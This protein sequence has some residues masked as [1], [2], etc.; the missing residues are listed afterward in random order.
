[1][2]QLLVLMVSIMNISD[3]LQFLKGVGPKKFDALKKL[4]LTTIEDFLNYYPRTYEDRSALTPFVEL[5]AGMSV[6]TAGT[7][8][9][10]MEKR[11]ARGMKLLLVRL[12]DGTGTL[13]AVWFNQPFLKKQLTVGSRLLLS[14]KIDYTYGGHGQLSMNQVT[15]FERLEADTPVKLGIIPVYPATEALNQKYLRKISRQIFDCQPKIDEVIPSAVVERY[16]LMPRAEAVREMHFPSDFESLKRAHDTLAF[17]ELYVIQCGLLILK[18]RSEQNQQG[19]RHMLSSNL[20][21][22]V[23]GA[24]PFA[25]TE[26]Q[27]KVLRD[28]ETDM[29]KK[30]P[31]HRLVQ[32]DVGSGK[33]VIALLALVKTVENGYQG[34]FMAP[35]EILAAQHYANFTKLL[36][37]TDIRVGL[38]SGSLSKKEHENIQQQLADHEIDIVIGTHA[39]IQEKVIFKSLGLVVTDE[40]HRFGIGQRAALK[41]K[42]EKT[43]DVLVMT[44]TPIPRTMTLTVYGDLDVSLI[45]HLPPGRQPIRTFVRERSRRQLI[46]D[47]VKKEIQSGRQA[48]VVCPLIEASDEMP[49]PSAEEVYTELSNGIF[50]GIPCG[51]L[52]GRLSAKEKDQIMNKFKAGELK[53]LVSTTVIEVGV[54]VPNASMMV[55]ENAD[56]FGL[57]QLHQLRGRIGRGPYKS[58]CVLIAGG[59]SAVG[60]ERLSIMENTANGFELAE[61][62]LKLRGP[63]QFFGSLQ[64]G[65]GDLKVADVLRDTD[66]LLKARRAALETLQ[67][68]ESL[69]AVVKVLSSRQYSNFSNISDN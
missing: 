54:D 58:Y 22:Q 43:P 29:E 60:K 33:T 24:L 48:Y 69:S 12:S 41:D 62:D 52:H 13:Q 26:D 65:L 14:G 55:I 64:H 16:R 68:N 45:E 56:R 6:T 30:T 36:A 51:L 21:K 20:F 66:I 40:Q 63:G 35:T 46:Y 19:I 25:L 11:S 49:L 23:Y 53:L 31:M 34:A 32:G 17:E 3:S 9:N 39:L 50:Q 42:A 57:A 28:I 59:K 18:K 5:A 47:F 67:D 61:A 1:M 38:L 10:V 2:L 37:G 4:G 7:I 27:Q 8:M 44:A 15:A